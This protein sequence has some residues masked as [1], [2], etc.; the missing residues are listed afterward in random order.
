MC[1]QTINLITLIVKYNTVTAHAHT[2]TKIRV[3]VTTRR[4]RV[5]LSQRAAPAPSAGTRKRLFTP[6]L[7]TFLVHKMLS[8]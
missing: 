1:E 2:F 3:Y 8:Q 5:Y 6:T 4:S 7:H